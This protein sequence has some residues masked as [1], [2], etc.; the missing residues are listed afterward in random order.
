MTA[1]VFVDAKAV[2]YARTVERTSQ[3]A[4]RGWPA[5]L[6]RKQLGCGAERVVAAI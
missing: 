5:R 2:L 4:A 3:A 1:P 6:S